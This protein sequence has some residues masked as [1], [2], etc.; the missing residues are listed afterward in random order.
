MDYKDYL[1]KQSAINLSYIAEKMWP[2]NKNAKSYLSTKLNDT[3]PKRPWTESDNEKAKHAINSLG[4][5][6]IKDAPIDSKKI[7]Q[8]GGV[9]TT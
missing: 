4:L 8:P 5:Q 6:L 9:K 1:L 2:T 7:K 3:D